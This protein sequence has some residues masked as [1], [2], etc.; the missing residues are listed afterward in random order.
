MIA[1]SDYEQVLIKA[2]GHKQLERLRYSGTRQLTNL[3]ANYGQQLCNECEMHVRAW[4]KGPVEVSQKQDIL[5]ALRGSGPQRTW[6]ANERHKRWIALGG[7]MVDLAGRD[8]DLSKAGA[9]ALYLLF[10]IKEARYWINARNERF[11][12][13]MLINEVR[14]ML[15]HPLPNEKLNPCSGFAYTKSVDPFSLS[16]L[17]S[18]DIKALL[19]IGIAHSSLT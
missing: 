4:L 18:S 10:Q 2:C 12:E 14:Y 19:G 1:T 8:D 17:R 11:D 13:T 16:A 15:R 5:P 3:K 6:A 9:K 7:L